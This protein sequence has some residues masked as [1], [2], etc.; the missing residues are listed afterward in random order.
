MESKEIKVE[1]KIKGDAERQA[2]WKS[3]EG[4]IISRKFLKFP[5]PQYPY[6]INGLNNISQILIQKTNMK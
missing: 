5:E 3:K 1:M 2:V 6:L 4:E